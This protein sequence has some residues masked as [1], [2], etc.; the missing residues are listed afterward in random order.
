MPAMV[1]HHVERIA[2]VSRTWF[3]YEWG[4][5]QDVIEL[6]LVVEVDFD[7]DPNSKSFQRNVI[8]AIYDTVTGVLKHDT[9]AILTRLR[10]IPGAARL[11]EL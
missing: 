9:A 4:P 11:V 1:R 10:I 8:N 6:T 7:T 2:G 3:E 5:G